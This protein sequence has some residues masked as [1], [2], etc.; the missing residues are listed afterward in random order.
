MRVSR[1]QLLQGA[2]ALA[3]LPLLALDQPSTGLAGGPEAREWLML[4]A[5]L[6]ITLGAAVPWRTQLLRLRRIRRGGATTQ[7]V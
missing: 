3:S 1:R 2:G 5:L 6:A 4:L 7:A